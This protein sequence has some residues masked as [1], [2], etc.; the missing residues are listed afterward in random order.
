MDFAEVGY[1]L[2]AN[3]IYLFMVCQG[4]VRFFNESDKWYK[5]TGSF[6]VI[7]KGKLLGLKILTMFL[8]TKV[9][10]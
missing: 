2:G 1:Q 9:N 8:E 7:L 10:I 5:Y 4:I 6:K 3:L